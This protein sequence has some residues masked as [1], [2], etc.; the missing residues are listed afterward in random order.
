M[1]EPPPQSWTDMCAEAKGLASAPNTTAAA[2]ILRALGADTFAVPNVENSTGT[3]LCGVQASQGGSACCNRGS[4]V[5]TYLTLPRS[6]L[7][8]VA[9]EL[10]SRKCQKTILQ[11]EAALLVV[12][13]E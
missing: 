11:F 2:A 10:D 3:T 4:C 13:L 8:E 1:P 6:H 5:T 12:T 9:L 7:S